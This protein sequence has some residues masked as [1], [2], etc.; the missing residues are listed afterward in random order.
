MIS[1]DVADLGALVPPKAF[2]ESELEGIEPE[3]G[4]VVA[5]HHMDV[6]WLVPVGHVEE[7]PVSPYSEN[8]RHVETI[9]PQVC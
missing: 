8:C 5:F 7:E 6:R 2:D 9:S 1:Y 3:L 4:G